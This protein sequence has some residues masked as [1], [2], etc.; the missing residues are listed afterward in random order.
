MPIPVAVRYKM[1][2]CGR[3]IAEIAGSNPAESTDIFPFF[4][5]VLCK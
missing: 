2:V 4:W 1:Y 5:C 3:L